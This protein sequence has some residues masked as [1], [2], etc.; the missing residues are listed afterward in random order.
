[1]RRIKPSPQDGIA[2]AAEY[3]SGWTVFSIEGVTEDGWPDTTIVAEQVT[4]QEATEI[5]E[6]LNA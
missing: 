5:M 1:M 4:E 3:T 2:W 6:R